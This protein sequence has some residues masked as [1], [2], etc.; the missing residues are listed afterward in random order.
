MTIEMN[1]GRFFR[2]K[3]HLDSSFE[4]LRCKP[5]PYTPDFEATLE[6]GT[7]LIESKHSWLIEKSP[8]ILGYPSILQRFGVRLVLVDEAYFPEVFSQNIRLL[9]PYQSL[10]LSNAE[11][12]RIISASASAATIGDLI[13]KQKIPQKLVLTAVANGFLHADLHTRR[14]ACSTCISTQASS[15]SSL[16]RLPL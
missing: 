10:R 13:E 14:L 7:V 16:E 2:S 6:T 4:G 1:T 12:T 9:H 11:K 3:E 5:R 8:E 15:N